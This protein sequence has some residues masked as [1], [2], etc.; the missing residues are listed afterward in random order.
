VEDIDRQTDPGSARGAYPASADGFQERA[1]RGREDR[2]LLVRLHR[3]GDQ[4]A[5]DQLVERFLPLA[6]QLARRYQHGG[7]QLDDLVQV[8]SLGLLKA[9]DRFDPARETAFSSFAVP[10]ILGELKRHFR[11]KGWAVRVPRDLQELAVRVDRVT[12]DL[13]GTLGRAPSIAEV[14]EHIG[15]TAEQ[16]LEAREASAAY[17]AVSLDRPRDDDDEG[18]AGGLADSVG[19]DDPGF[20]LAEDAATVERL[21]RVLS[22]REREVLRLRF[23]EDLTQ[24][25]IGARVG[26]SQMHVSRLIRH[27]IAALREA[28]ER[29]PLPPEPPR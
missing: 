26:V 27:A 8:A 18:E 7:E 1:A 21:M 29:P 16:V 3:H 2:R 23:A 28:A 10:T 4:A 25:D 13:A 15:T 9:I 14:A 22:E 5:R 12:E 19:D 24:S 17:R 11:D 20:G 6:R